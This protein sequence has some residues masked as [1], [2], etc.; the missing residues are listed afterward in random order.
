MSVTSIWPTVFLM[1]GYLLVGAVISQQDGFYRKITKPAHSLRFGA[2]DGLRGFHALGVFF[3]HCVVSRVYFETGSWHS[4][5]SQFYSLLGP[6]SVSMFFMITGFLFWDKAI[7]NPAQLRPV[8][9]Y[10]GRF[11]RIAPLYFFSVILILLVVACRSGFRI[12]KAD[13]IFPSILRALSVGL[14]TCWSLNGISLTSI[15]AGVLWTLSYEWQ[16]YLALPFM[17]WF[18]TGKRFF[19]FAGVLLA[20]CWAWPEYFR[21]TFLASSGMFRQFFIERDKGPIRLDGRRCPP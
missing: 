7:R 19:P 9:L 13:D 17:S 16:F 15:N 4:P 14:F 2:L 5:A 20:L 11:L 18:A 6:M 3:H 8:V 1:G 12:Q 21:V 10:K